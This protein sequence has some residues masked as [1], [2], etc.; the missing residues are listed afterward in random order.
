[1]A[2]ADFPSRFGQFRIY[3]FAYT[4]GSESEEV[5]ALKMGDLSKARKSFDAFNDEWDNIE[6][7][8][9]ARSQ[10]SYVAIESGM[11]QIEKAIGDAKPDTTALTTLV[12]GV[13]DK[14]NAIV[15]QVTREARTAK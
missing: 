1:M 12:N 10:D 4:A 14:Y 6:D 11:I 5:V 2:E 3:G 8:V 9:K 7:L 13:M 15:S